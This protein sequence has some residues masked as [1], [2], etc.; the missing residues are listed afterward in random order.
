MVERSGAPCTGARTESGHHEGDS[1]CGYEV[2]EVTFHS[3]SQLAVVEGDTRQ[4]GS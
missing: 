2:H 4:L 3:V 1:A